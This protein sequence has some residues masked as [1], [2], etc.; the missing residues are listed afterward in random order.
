MD[1]KMKLKVIDCFSV[2]TKVCDFVFFYDF[3]AFNDILFV[4]AAQLEAFFPAIK[5]RRRPAIFVSWQHGSLIFGCAPNPFFGKNEFD[6][7]TLF[8]TRPSHS[9]SQGGELD[10]Q[11]LRIKDNKRI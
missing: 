3:N 6:I 8:M 9:D 2:K 11:G 1:L 5:A 10:P 4:N 7:E